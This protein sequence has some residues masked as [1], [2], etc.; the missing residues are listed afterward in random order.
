[1]GDAYIDITL[2]D[3][4]PLPPGYY[5]VFSSFP[6]I[7]GTSWVLAAF[8]AHSGKPGFYTGDVVHGEIVPIAHPEIKL[9]AYK[10]DTPAVFS[11]LEGTFVIKLLE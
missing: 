1:L 7:Y 4:R 2:K 10:W 6:A 5:T 9:T 8:M 3:L 11:T